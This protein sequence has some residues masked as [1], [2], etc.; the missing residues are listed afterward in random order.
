MSEFKVYWIHRKSHSDIET[1]GYVGI[2]RETVESRFQRHLRQ[3]KSGQ[4]LNR[5]LSSALKK[6]EDIVLTTICICDKDYALLMENKLRPTKNIGWNIAVGGITNPYFS[7]PKKVKEPKPRKDTSGPNHPN[8]QGGIKNWRKFY[9]LLTES[10]QAQAERERKKL[11][12]ELREK[13]PRQ[14]RST[15][16]IQKLAA[17]KRKYFEE[18]GTWANHQADKYLWSKSQDIYLMWL[19]DM[20]GCRALSRK[21]GIPRSTTIKGMIKRFNDG[22]VPYLDPRFLEFLNERE[23]A[24]N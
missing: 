22:W 17:A 10:P 23:K 12:K 4:H 19:E 13:Q 5:H 16:H 7:A 3:S 2:T 1:E 21:L 24:S 20:C 15:E 11:E 8:W 18:R 9:C 14:P 6:Y